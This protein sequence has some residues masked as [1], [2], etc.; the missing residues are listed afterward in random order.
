MLERCEEEVVSY[1]CDDCQ[2]LLCRKCSKDH[3]EKKKHKLSLYIKSER[4][5]EHNGMKEEFVCLECLIEICKGCLN[6]VDGKHK[7]HKFGSIIEESNLIKTDKSLTEMQNKLDNEIEELEKEILENK[8]KK[9]QI[10]MIFKEEGT[11]IQRYKLYKELKVNDTD[12][13]LSNY[14]Q[15]KEFTKIKYPFQL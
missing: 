6:P 1:Q 15:T 13:I 11:F 8:K 3:T 9:S 7:D 14:K 4:C 12:I 5:Y 10:E 2:K